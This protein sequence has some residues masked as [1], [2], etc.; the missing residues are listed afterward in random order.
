MKRIAGEEALKTELREWMWERGLP[1]DGT[2]STLELHSAVMMKPGLWPK[3]PE[4]L[5][6][7]GRQPYSIQGDFS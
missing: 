6:N 5:K 4:R 2:E 7:A 3:L 1:S